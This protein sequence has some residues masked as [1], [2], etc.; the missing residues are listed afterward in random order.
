MWDGCAVEQSTPQKP[1][2]MGVDF[3]CSSKSESPFA[4]VIRVI[5]VI[6]H[7]SSKKKL[8]WNL[9]I[10][11][12]MI[13]TWFSKPFIFK[14]PCCGCFLEVNSRYS[15]ATEFPT[16]DVLQLRAQDLFCT[17]SIGNRIYGALAFCMAAMVQLTIWLELALLLSLPRTLEHWFIDSLRFIDNVTKIIINIC[18]F[19]FGWAWNDGDRHKTCF[20]LDVSCSMKYNMRVWYNDYMMYWLLYIIC[21]MYKTCLTLK[22]TTF[23]L[24]E[25][26]KIIH[27]ILFIYIYTH[28]Y[29]Y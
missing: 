15:T 13:L 2:K 1:W 5:K 19:F 12:H 21:V 18:V 28:V 20:P 23:S 27:D 6:K 3:P 24:E 16:D 8:R 10:T 9:N 11:P 26:L 25:K 4:R 7:Y 14:I 17:I 22:S 29:V